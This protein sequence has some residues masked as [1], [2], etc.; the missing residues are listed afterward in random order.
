MTTANSVSNAITSETV[1][2]SPPFFGISG[3]AAPPLL[4]VVIEYSIQ[5]VNSNFS[6]I[7]SGG[8]QLAW[9]SVFMLVKQDFGRV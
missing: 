8:G 9:S 1:M 6:I 5:Y 2:L 4:D 3:R 7:F